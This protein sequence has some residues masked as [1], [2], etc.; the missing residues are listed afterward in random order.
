MEPV[1]KTEEEW[2]KELSPEAFEVLREQGTEAPFSGAFVNNHEK[3]AYTCKACGSML[4]SSEAPAGLPSP[5]LQLLRTS[6]LGRTMRTVCTAPKSIVRN[7]AA[8]WA[9]SST[10]DRKKR[11][12]S[13]TALTPSASTLRKTKLLSALGM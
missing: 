4:F 9:M 5:T 3:G 13:A 6:A 2:R 11:A 8:T 12:A 1:Q 7:V 10:M